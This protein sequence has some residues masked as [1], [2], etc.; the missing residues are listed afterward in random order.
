MAKAEISVTLADLPTVKA[1]VER[2]ENEVDDLRHLL[3]T[4]EERVTCLQ[5]G[6]RYT[7]RA[8]GP[9]HAVIRAMVEGGSGADR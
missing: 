1:L 5:C 4:W 8:C 6:E 7:K 9:T 3:Q 2:L